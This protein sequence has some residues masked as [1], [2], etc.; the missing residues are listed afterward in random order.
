MFVWKIFTTFNKNFKT[1]KVFNFLTVQTLMLTIIF[2]LSI[3]C[4][5]NKKLFK[6]LK[7]QTKVNSIKWLNNKAKITLAENIA[8]TNSI[9]QYL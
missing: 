2:K 3:S 8:T 5:I 4:L 7:I 9:Y 6:S 1:V